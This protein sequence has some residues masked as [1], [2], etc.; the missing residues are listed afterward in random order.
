MH[1]KA[2]KMMRTTALRMSSDVVIQLCS[3]VHS[4]T[5]L[6]QKVEGRYLLW[7]TDTQIYFGLLYLLARLKDWE[8]GFLTEYLSP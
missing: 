7:G 8:M 6:M 3:K 2:K 5:W 4:N 1:E